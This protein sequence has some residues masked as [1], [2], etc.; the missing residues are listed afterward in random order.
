MIDR[1]TPEEIAVMK[2]GGVLLGG[3]L[4]ELLDMARP[5]V[6]LL[7]LEKH[8]VKRIAEVGAKPSFASVEG[9]KWAT[10]LCVNDEVVHGIPIQ[11]MLVDGD[12]LTIDVGLIYEGF[13][14]DTA[15]TKIVTGD[16]QQGTSDEKHRFLKVG[17]DALWAAIAQVKIG[18]HIGHISEVVQNTIEAAGY[19]IIKT[20]VGHGVGRT[21]H[22]E[23]Q[24]PNY[25]PAGR[26]GLRGAIENTTK[27]IGGETIAVEVIY[28]IGNGTIEY[29]RDDG[30]TLG[31][32]DRTL[33]A[34]FEHTIAVCSDGPLVLTKV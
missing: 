34:V 33:T 6:N 18:S 17:E 32:K 15:W 24:V 12:V 3:I 4:R 11:Y 28:A 9:Y 23:P 8:A 2:K 21:L 25:L 14:T 7:D 26:H 27:L 20:L 19:S 10:C 30:W 13:H 31:T 16:K 5:G 22:E 29:C 1:K